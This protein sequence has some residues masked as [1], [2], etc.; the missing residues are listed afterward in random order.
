MKKKQK[1]KANPIAS[2]RF[3]GQPHLGGYLSCGPA[4]F[5]TAKAKKCAIKEASGLKCE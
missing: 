1:T 4:N 2:G 5:K 3:A